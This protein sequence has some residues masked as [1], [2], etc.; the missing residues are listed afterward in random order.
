VNEAPEEGRGTTGEG[1]ASGLPRRNHLGGPVPVPY[2]SFAVTISISLPATAGDSPPVEARKRCKQMKAQQPPGATESGGAT[3][4]G[5]SGR[6]GGA[7]AAESAGAAGSG[8]LPPTRKPER[9][10]DRRDRQREAER[11]RLRYYIL[12]LRESNPRS[13]V[14]HRERRLAG[15]SHE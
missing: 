9:Q 14:F 15:D 4:T 12:P 7:N 5:G 3:A 2:P 6:G 11:S 10:R 13:V 8:G 1:R